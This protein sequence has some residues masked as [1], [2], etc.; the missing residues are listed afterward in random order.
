LYRP[1][2]RNQLVPSMLF[3]Q[4]QHLKMA[5][6]LEDRSEMHLDP[7]KAKKQIA[8]AN[9]FR[10]LAQRVARGDGELQAS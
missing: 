6:L 1:K 10:V 3:S 8:M 2:L 5:S 7:A 4:R 9:L